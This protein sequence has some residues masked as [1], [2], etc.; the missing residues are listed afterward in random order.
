VSQ[1]SVLMQLAFCGNFYVD[2]CA[3]KIDTA[4]V[5]VTKLKR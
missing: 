5:K 1:A 4:A 2:C 3:L